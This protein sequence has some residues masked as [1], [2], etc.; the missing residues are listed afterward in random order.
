MAKK[1]TLIRHGALSPELD[2]CY[3]G[4]QDVPMSTNG[5]NQALKLA[6]RLTH[7][8]H[9]SIDAL[10]CSPALRAKQTANPIAK[11]LALTCTIKEELNEVD[12]GRWEGLSFAQICADDPQLVDQWAALNDEFSFPEGESQYHFQQRVSTIYTQIHASAHAHVALITHGG[13]IRA[14]LCQLLEL[15]RSDYL[16]FEINRGSFV[17][18]DLHQQHA[19]LTGLYNDI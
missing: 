7:H 10:W 2:G 1:L 6:N 8:A 16:K 13:V 5:H 4:Q 9:H 11:T 17:T 14:L 3:V 18:F 12:F 19:V 15:P